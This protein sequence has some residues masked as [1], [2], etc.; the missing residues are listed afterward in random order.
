MMSGVSKN[1]EKEDKLTDGK[2]LR[3]SFSTIEL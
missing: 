1:D 3:K 2:V